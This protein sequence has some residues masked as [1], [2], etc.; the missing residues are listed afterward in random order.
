MRLVYFSP[1]HAR[2]YAQRPHYTVQAWLD[3]GAESVLWVDPYPC[4]LPR[5]GDL[6]RRP[7]LNNQETR[8]DPRITVLEV[9]ALPIEP[10]PAGAWFNRRFLWG[11]VG[12][13]IARFAGHGPTILGIGRPSALA[14]AVLDQWRPAA[15]FYEAMDNFP[16]FHSGLSRRSVRHYEDLISAR[17]DLIV[18]SSTFLAEK[19]ARRG[20]RVEKVV[21]AYAMSTLPEYDSPDSTERRPVLG[22]IGCLGKWIDWPLMVRLA[23]SFPEAAIELVGPCAVPPPQDLPANIRLLPPCPQQEAGNHLA[24]FSVG[25]IPFLK[26][27]LTAGMDPIKYYEYRAMG[28]P[29]LSTSFGEMVYR[30]SQ[31]GVY[32]LDSGEDLAA[33]VRR[34]SAH[35]FSPADVAAFRSQN[36]WQVRFRSTAP[37][38][39]LVS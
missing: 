25:L 4:R 37:F 33:V 15:T 35:R 22:F 34:A 21:N 5:W 2:S 8:L 17:A 13:Q 38:R 14:L 6:R 28:L 24:R 1:V 39:Q 23:R 29:M 32:F 20:R 12:R 9:P 26:T 19:F 31:D 16:E 30:G 7:L 11:P 10:L 36:D 27:P 3:L 18:A